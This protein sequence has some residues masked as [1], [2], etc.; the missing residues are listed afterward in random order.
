MYELYLHIKKEKGERE[1]SFPVYSYIFH[2]TG[3]RYK[4]PKIHT[5]K[6]CDMFQMKVKNCNSEE[7]V[8]IQQE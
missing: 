7:K 6:A 8:A 3:L 1:P 2:S 4:L 5:C